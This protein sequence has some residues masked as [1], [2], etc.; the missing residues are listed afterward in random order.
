MEAR[1]QRQSSGGAQRN[2]GRRLVAALRQQRWRKLGKGSIGN[3]IVLVAA[4]W[5]Q[6]RGSGRLVVGPVSYGCAIHSYTQINGLLVDTDEKKQSMF[7][8]VKYSDQSVTHTLL[9]LFL[10]F[11]IPKIFSV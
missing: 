3:S 8:F 11:S 5:R 4:W 7:C 9:F 2:G 1:Q 6:Q 10:F